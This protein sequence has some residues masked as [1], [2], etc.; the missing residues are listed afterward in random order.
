MLK[1]AATVLTMALVLAGCVSVKLPEIS[2][3]RFFSDGD[4]GSPPRAPK[5]KKIKAKK[6][7]NTRK[8]IEFKHFKG[9]CFVLV[10]FFSGNQPESRAEVAELVRLR[11]KWRRDE[12]VVVGVHEWLKGRDLT[13]RLK[14]LGIQYPVA[15][16]DENDTFKDYKLTGYP[17][18]VLV[19]KDERIADEGA[20]PEVIKTLEAKLKE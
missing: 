13:E 15:M 1:R 11:K 5:A 7:Y 2:N 20:L 3:I 8:K 18:T 17:Y 16:D 6:W 14:R 19:G 4:D 10:H 12:V 9:R